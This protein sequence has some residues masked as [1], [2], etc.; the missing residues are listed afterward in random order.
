MK[1]IYICY[2]NK[3]HR[4]EIEVLCMDYQNDIGNRWRIVAT[5]NLNR[6]AK[7]HIDPQKFESYSKLF[8][9]SIEG[10]KRY[11][12]IEVSHLS[13]SYEAISRSRK[14]LEDHGI[15]M[16]GYKELDRQKKEEM[17]ITEETSFSFQ[18]MFPSLKLKPLMSTLS[19]YVL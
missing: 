10:L 4:Y 14:M 8:E 11:D 18:N 9:R 3:L 6:L 17:K 1:S 16:K 5:N 2:A 7:N 19:S 12:P 15:R 13:K